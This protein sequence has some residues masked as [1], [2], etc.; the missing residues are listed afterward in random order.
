MGVEGPGWLLGDLD[1]WLSDPQRRDKLLAVLRRIEA[2][3]SIMGV[4]AHLLAVGHRR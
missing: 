3:P 2:E 4:S 1:D